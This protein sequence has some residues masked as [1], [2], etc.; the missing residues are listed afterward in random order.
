[1][2]DL[3][4]RLKSLAGEVTAAQFGELMLEGSPKGNECPYFYYNGSQYMTTRD[5]ETETPIMRTPADVINVEWKRSDE[6]FL[7]YVNRKAEQIRKAKPESKVPAPELSLDKMPAALQ[8]KL[9]AL[10]LDKKPFTR[11]DLVK[12]GLSVEDLSQLDKMSQQM[13]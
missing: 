2:S 1:M 13:S 6:T 4:T 3:L 5:G 8:E 11:E 12:A 7:D 9:T 10:G